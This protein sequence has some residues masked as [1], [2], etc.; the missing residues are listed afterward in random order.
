MASVCRTTRAV[1]RGP[2]ARNAFETVG[3]W[4]FEEGSS[5]NRS[6][7]CSNWAK[8]WLFSWSRCLNTSFFSLSLFL[9]RTQPARFNGPPNEQFHELSSFPCLNVI[10]ASMYVWNTT[11]WRFRII[12]QKGTICNRTGTNNFQLV[13]RFLSTFD[14]PVATCFLIGIASQ[15]GKKKKKNINRRLKPLHRTPRYKM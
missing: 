5:R 15:E 1:S 3:C 12:F 10:N 8:K 6:F 2:C 13:A 14:V 9:D 11:W 7:S 4:V